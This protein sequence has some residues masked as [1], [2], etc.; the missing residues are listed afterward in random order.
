MREDFV[1]VQQSY[2]ICIQ[3]S[4]DGK[5]SGKDSKAKASKELALNRMAPVTGSNL[6]LR[7][8]RGSRTHTRLRA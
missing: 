5:A 2:F 6:V 4:Q 3:Q 8:P 7:C 1:C